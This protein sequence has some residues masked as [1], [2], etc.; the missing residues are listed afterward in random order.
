VNAIVRQGY[1]EEVD[2][3]LMLNTFAQRAT[4]FTGST[5]ADRP[6]SAMLGGSANMTDSKFYNSMLM[7]FTLVPQGIG[8]EIKAGGT[9]I[10]VDITRQMQKRLDSGIG[11]GINF[12]GGD[13][14]NDD[15]ESAKDEDVDFFV[16]SSF[17]SDKIYVRDMPGADTAEDTLLGS[18]STQ[19]PGHYVAQHNM[20]EFVRF[21]F[22]GG[23]FTN[24][25]L[26]FE[27]SR[28]SDKIPWHSQVDLVSYFDSNPGI[29]KW[30]WKRSG[31]AGAINEIDEGAITIIGP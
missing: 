13:R 14:Q 31:A 30:F 10:V 22:D 1:P 15:E 18:D 5:P 3:P 11:S 2:N 26:T 28:G 16:G 8:A 23:A 9:G 21:R 29:N 27:G 24:A 19:S 4:F 20:R 25:D 7:E 17:V 6:L 12:R